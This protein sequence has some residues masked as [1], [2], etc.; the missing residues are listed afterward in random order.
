MFLCGMIDKLLGRLIAQS[1]RWLDNKTNKTAF[2]LLNVQTLFID[3]RNPSKKKYNKNL[4]LKAKTSFY[5]IIINKLYS[6][7]N[8]YSSKA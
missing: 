6:E 2:I 3:Y 7:P 5:K 4:H 1:K 8:V